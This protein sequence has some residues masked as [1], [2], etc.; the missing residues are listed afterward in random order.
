V[1]AIIAS[2]WVGQL[3]MRAGLIFAIQEV[4]LAGKPMTSKYQL[5]LQE[6]QAA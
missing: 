6:T 5:C 1:K 2:Q 4:G 3:V